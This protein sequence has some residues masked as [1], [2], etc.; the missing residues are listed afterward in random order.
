MVETT[1]QRT[2]DALSTQ[3]LSDRA[4]VRIETKCALAMLG[5]TMR[6][7]VR[8]LI[9]F[10]DKFAHILRSLPIQK[11]WERKSLLI[12]LNNKKNSH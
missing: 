8:G 5:Y 1:K 12:R 7:R 11:D 3:L 4:E 2:H 10:M 6:C 9:P